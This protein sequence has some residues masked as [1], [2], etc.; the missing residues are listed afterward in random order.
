MKDIKEKTAWEV[1]KDLPARLFR[2]IWKFIGQ[3]GAILFLTVWLIKTDTF[4]AEAEPYLYGFIVLLVLFGI[5]GLKFLKDI[6]K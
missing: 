6:K 5:E 1:I 3:K 2:M 4:P